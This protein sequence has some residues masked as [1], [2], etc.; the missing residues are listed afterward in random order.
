MGVVVPRVFLERLGFEVRRPQRQ[1]LESRLDRSKSFLIPPP[2]TEIVSLRL[3]AFR[4]MMYLC[5][6]VLR[7]TSKVLEVYLPPLVKVLDSKSEGKN[8]YI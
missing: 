7:L 8:S 4:R 2:S 5:F 6:K 1:C 3:L